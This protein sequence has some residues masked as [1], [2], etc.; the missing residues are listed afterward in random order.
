MNIFVLSDD[1]VKAAQMQCDKHVLKMVTE[2]AQML[3]TV[4]RMLDGFQ[5]KVPSK[6]G[7]TMRKT[8]LFGDARDEHFYKSVHEHHPCTIW[9]MESSANYFWH[10]THFKALA[11]EFEYRYSKPH[12][13]WEK[14]HELIYHRLPKNITHGPLTEFA[15]AM[16]Q[17]PECVVNGSPVTSYRNFYHADK[18]RFATWNRGREAPDWWL[19]EDW[20]LAS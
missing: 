14:T 7:K 5:T 9:T 18:L 11:N 13:A 19:G 4:H 2:S 20:K 16:K 12:G 8:W 17:Y 6:S 3:C 1:P 15:T 10:S